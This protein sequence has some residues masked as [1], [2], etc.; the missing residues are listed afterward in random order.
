MT[1]ISSL[2]ATLVLAA[3]S[4]VAHAAEF[5]WRRFAGQ[6]VTVMLPEHPVTDGVRTL[7]DQFERDTGMSVRMQ[8]MAEDLY[9]DRMEV[10]LRGSSGNADVYFLPMDSTAYTQY[11]A[12]LIKPLSPYIDDPSMT[13]PDYDVRDFPAGFLDTTR[14]PGGT[15]DSMYYGIPASFEVYILFYNKDLVNQYLGGKVPGTMP[16][17]IKAAEKIKRDSGGQVAGAVMRGIRSD[18]LIDTISGVVFNSWGNPSDVKA[19]YGLWFDGGWNKPRVDDPRIVRGLADYAGLM[20]AG[21]INILSIDWPDAEQVFKQQRAA[22]F[23]DAS[24]FAPGF[25]DPSSPIS[26]KVGYRLMPPQSAGGKSYTAHWG[27]GFG[28]PANADNP[29]AGWYFIQYMTNK[30]SEPKIGKLH[31]GAVRNSSQ[32]NREYTSSLNPD[33]AKVVGE[34]TKTSKTSVVFREGFSELA[35]VLV[36]A[37][38]KIYGGESPDGAAGEAQ[39]SFKRIASN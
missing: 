15:P 4:V 35:L 30:S 16:E 36:D 10:A 25:E 9:F 12:G 11:S 20:K 7:I 32:T 8:T 26:G 21:P 28:V 38:Q 29:E 17:L 14:Y 18:T 33:Y 31:W 39:N 2:A 22:F 5:D 6:E 1:K 19:P 34:A 24:L 27:W 23:I 37:I 3:I 13:S